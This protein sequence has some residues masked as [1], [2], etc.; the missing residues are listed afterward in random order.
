M[1]NKYQVLS[2]L[3]ND[4]VLLEYTPANLNTK[5]LKNHFFCARVVSIFSSSLSSNT[6]HTNA[7]SSTLGS[8][9]CDDANPI[10]EEAQIPPEEKLSQLEIEQETWFLQTLEE[11]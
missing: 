9:P 5:K 4:E 11:Y 10:Y 6:G 1:Q 8:V 2:T 7:P 3:S